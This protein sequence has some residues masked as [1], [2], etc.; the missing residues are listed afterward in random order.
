[1]PAGLTRRGKPV[2]RTSDLVAF[3]TRFGRFRLLTN[4]SSTVATYEGGS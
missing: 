4:D 2:P 1:M 3:G